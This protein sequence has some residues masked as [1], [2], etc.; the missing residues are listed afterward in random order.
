MAHLPVFEDSSELFPTLSHP[1]EASG[2]Y[3]SAV[4]LDPAQQAFV[5]RL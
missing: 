2:A 4:S 3:Y 1:D 5:Y